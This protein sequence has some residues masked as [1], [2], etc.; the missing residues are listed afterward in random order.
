MLNF[1]S[2]IV[3]V[4]SLLLSAL[5]GPALA[6]T[7]APATCST[8]PTAIT[9]L[10]L[11][12]TVNL[13]LGA[14]AGSGTTP[15]TGVTTP[16]VFSTLTP[17]VPTALIAPIVAG[18][19]EVRQQVS[20]NTQSNVLTIESFTAQPGSPSPTQASSINSSSVIEVSAIQV[21]KTY[22]SC[23]PVPS[24][25]ITGRVI[26]NFPNTPWG[27]INGALVAVGMGYTTD[28]PA[29]LNNL[30]ILVPGEFGIYSGTASGTL[31]FPTS[32]VNPPTTSGTQPVIVFSPSATQTVYQRQIYLDASQSKDPSNLPLT[33]SWT[34]VNTN[35]QAGIANA[36]SATPLVTFVSRG[37]YIFQVVVTNSQGV[38]NTA[39]TT[40]TY[41]G[42]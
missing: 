30:T 9:N 10:L 14:G 26:N 39:Q 11:E 5:V 7:T 38:Q 16:G 27:N 25:L 42:Q 29:K 19:L 4:C 40:I 12:R 6:Q 41:N 32:A 35:I 1:R 2:K 18:A 23:Q 21:D 28:T 34:Q 22:F 15:G 37:D 8:A 17:N 3:P 31:T 33:Y 36:T 20:L 13:G 24:I